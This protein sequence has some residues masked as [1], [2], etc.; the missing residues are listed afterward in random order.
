VRNEL[1]T[2][3]YSLLNL[4]SSYEWKRARFDFGIENI[5]DKFYAQPLGGAYVG[6]GNVMGGGATWGIPVPG[7]GRSVFA[8]VTVKF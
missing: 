2:D 8:G 3:A 1:E 5:F 4:R 7:M 6:E